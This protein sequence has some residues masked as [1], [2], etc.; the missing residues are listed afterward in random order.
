MKS[1]ISNLTDAISESLSKIAPENQ[2]QLASLVKEHNIEIQYVDESGF[3]IRVTKSE[4]DNQ[5]RIILP[6]ASLEYL[7]CF[8]HFFWVFTQ[9]YSNAQKNNES[10]LHI[11]GN[12]RLKTSIELLSWA[13][14]NLKSTNLKQWP[15]IY[16][17]PEMVNPEMDDSV[18]A[19]EIFLCAIAWI[20][21]HEMAHVVLKHPLINTAFSTQEENDADE[22]ATNWIL[23]ECNTES[24]QFQKRKIGIITGLLCLQSLDVSKIASENNTH[25]PAC[26]R[27]HRNM[28][29]YSQEGSEVIEA[30]CVVI[31]QYLFHGKGIKVDINGKDFISILGGLLVDIQRQS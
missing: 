20:M 1:P 2:N 19:S 12:E 10:N 7:W 24:A 29:R 4:D 27:I 13:R 23:K 11:D 30:L 16:P 8:C 15:D 26:E 6:V 14:D 18:V 17:R 9:E 25:P 22:Y 21:H 28:V 3:G 5:Y 31:L